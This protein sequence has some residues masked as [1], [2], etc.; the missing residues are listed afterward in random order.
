MLRLLR[1]LLFWVI[2]ILWTSTVYLTDRT[3]GWDFILFNLIRLPLMMMTTYAII[4]GLLPRYVLY[5]KAYGKF[6]LAFAFLFLT[7]TL[8]DRWLIGTD[9]IDRLLKHTGL[10]YTFF[11][12]IPLIRNAFVLLSI[13]GL[14]TI[15]RLFNFY[16]NQTPTKSIAPSLNGQSLNTKQTSLLSSSKP[17]GNEFLLKS[18]AI[19]HKLSWDDILFLEKDENYVVYHTKEKRVLERT[20]L[21]KLSPKLPDYFCRV[22]RSFIISIKKIENIERDFLKI[23]G[24]KIP[25]GRTYRSRFLDKMKD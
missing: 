5:Q 12:E 20:T 10:T 24:Q 4:Y 14:A 22:H 6:I 9:L 1:H 15:I 19:T 13:I 23:N 8:L 25:I 16:Q 11:N 17:I 7:T 21:S 3:T 18:G 2:I